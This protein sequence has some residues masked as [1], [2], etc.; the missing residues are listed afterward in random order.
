[1]T[2]EPAPAEVVPVVAEV[3]AQDPDPVAEESVRPVDDD[4]AGEGQV[5]VPTPVQVLES[6]KESSPSPPPGVD[7]VKLNFDR[8]VFRLIGTTFLSNFAF[9][10]G[11]NVNLT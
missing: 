2:Q 3:V 4:K 9:G 8:K 10:L 11:L 1:V 6:D 5:E 7:F